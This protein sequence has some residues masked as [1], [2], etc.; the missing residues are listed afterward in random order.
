MHKSDLYT[1]AERQV[2]RSMF[3]EGKTD[4]EIVRILPGRTVYGVSKYRSK[5]GWV[6]YKK[7]ETVEAPTRA[8]DLK[9][10]P[11]GSLFNK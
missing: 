6:Q 4:L 3:Y 9:T 5:N 11:Q 1:P 8:K 2:I 10:T 7:G